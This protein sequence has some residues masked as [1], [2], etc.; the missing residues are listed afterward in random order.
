MHCT[1]LTCCSRV[2]CV[3]LKEREGRGGEI[4]T[5]V[6]NCLKLWEPE[7]V[8]KNSEEEA[9][10]AAAHIANQSD[11]DNCIVGGRAND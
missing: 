7:C 9:S 8:V 5:R 2:C 1:L 11:F 10:F 6:I 3:E 4:H